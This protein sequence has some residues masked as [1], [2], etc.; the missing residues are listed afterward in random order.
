MRFITEL[1]SPVLC[2]ILFKRE[3]VRQNRVWVP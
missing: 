1:V 3:I 2:T